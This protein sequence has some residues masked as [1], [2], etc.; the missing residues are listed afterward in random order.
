MLICKTA[1]D[2][3]G[4]REPRGAAET[5]RASTSTRDGGDAEDHVINATDKSDAL[6]ARYINNHKG[7]FVESL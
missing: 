5:S 7:R 2:L 3:S 1:G 6:E 4:L